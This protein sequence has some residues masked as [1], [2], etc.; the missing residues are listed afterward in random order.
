MKQR[1]T[2]LIIIFLLAVAGG[3][4]L[5]SDPWTTTG[6]ELNDM[7][8]PKDADVSRIVVISGYDTLEVAHKDSSWYLEGEALNSVAIENLLFAA[9]R[10]QMI[11]VIPVSAIIEGG[12]L[13]EFIFQGKRKMLANFYFG[14]TGHGDAV[15]QPGAE[16]G[17]GVEIPG[18]EDLPL[19]KVFSAN[20]D[21]YRKHLLVSLLPSEVRSVTVIPHSGISFHAAQDSLYNI[22]VVDLSGMRDLTDRINERKV[23]MLF[24]YFNAIRYDEVVT[25]KDIEPGTITDAPYATVEVTS[26]DDR[27]WKFDIY[28][29]IKTDSEAPD[30]FESL[31]IVNGTLPYRSVNYYYLDLL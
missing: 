31:V 21:H 6:R 11:G 3:Y 27:E 13:T 29:W 10:L 22:E 25:D 12:E 17:Y 24:S 14:K 23:R 1:T 26:F 8:L 28:Q 2:I 20:R 7:L 4:L 19:E 5:L 15:F 18:F 9:A 30:L 16:T